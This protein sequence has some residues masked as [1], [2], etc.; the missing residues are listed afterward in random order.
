VSA[1]K[2]F[3]RLKALSD[4]PAENR[5]EW[6]SAAEESV[7]FLRTNAYSDH[8]VI[9]AG[10]PNVFIHGVL[11]PLA[12]LDPPDED[13]LLHASVQ[14]GNGWIIQRSYGGGEGHRVY[15][16]PPLAYPGCK[17]LVGGEKLVF[18]RHFEGMRN[19][20]VQIE[21]NQKLVHSF[22]LHY[23]PERHAYCRLD[24]NGDLE[25]VITILN[26]TAAPPYWSGTA[27][28]IA[29]KDIAEY[30]ALTNQALVRK[31]DFMRV[32]FESFPGWEDAQRSRRSAPDLFYN[33]AVMP[34]HASYA[35]G[36]Q[37]IKSSLTPEAMADE[38][39]RSIDPA[40][41]R[42]ETF[43]IQD[44]KNNRLVEWSCAPDSLAN[45][46]TES[47]KPFEV[48]PAFFKPEV[49]SKYK[50]DPDKYHI[51][52]RS[53]TCRNSWYLK[54]YDINDA[55]QVH[56]YILY[57]ANLPYEEQQYWKLFNEW[58]KEPIS[59]RAFQTDFEGTWATEHDPLQEIRHSIEELDRRRPGWW[60]PR[61]DELLRA[62][63]YPATESAKE[64]GD[65]LLALDQL[66]V[67]GFVP[68]QLR[69]LAER[70]G[71]VIEKNWGSLK[72]IEALLLA[73]GTPP[74]QTSGIME[75]LKRLHYL[76]TKVKGHAS[77]TERHELEVAARTEHLTFRAHFQALAR[78]CDAALTK[79][80]TALDSSEWT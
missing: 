6:L 67:E 74:D 47:D 54:T 48:S 18:R 4:V 59:K 28:L 77:P 51:E 46:F 60:K 1:R 42:Y 58:P 50:A 36:C 52:D 65:E 73:L 7:E 49:L 26:T 12:A 55:G 31:F 76:R 78:G 8:I 15:L 5:P 39:K 66:I 19:F 63:L 22:D 57:L 34:G 69:V 53:I 24:K 27:V 10:L 40:R 37:I 14:I 32:L 44:W 70:V 71:I 30:M 33:L 75:P 45:Y 20:T 9:Y 11:A 62:V 21:I 80:I 56:T 35:N 43:K 17:S 3:E 23:L 2:E 41:R 72:I 61:G 16:E 25:D 64:W 13:D 68:K 29:A 79:I 38:W